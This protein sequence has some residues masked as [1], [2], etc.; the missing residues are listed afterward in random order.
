MQQLDACEI[1]VVIFFSNEAN[2]F[3]ERLRQS[4]EMTNSGNRKSQYCYAIM[5]EYVKCCGFGH[6]FFEKTHWAIFQRINEALYLD[7]LRRFVV[8]KI[9]SRILETPRGYASPDEMSDVFQFNKYSD[10]FC[11]LR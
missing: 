6:H 11:H 9:S 4:S 10:D 8:V 1:D 5:L 3:L 7:L 2:F